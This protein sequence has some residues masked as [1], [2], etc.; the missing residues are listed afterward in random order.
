MKN[1]FSVID[2]SRKLSMNVVKE[3]QDN[4]FAVI[5]DLITCDELSNLIAAYDSAVASALAD[6]VKV[7]S[8]TTR[9]NDFVNR[10]VE[11]DA[12]AG[13]IVGEPFSI[14]EGDREIA[15]AELSPVITV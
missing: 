15:R 6:D 5:S 9:V 4:G 10:G 8:T 7:G 14:T 2:A 12:K 3:L 1:W 11:F 13:K